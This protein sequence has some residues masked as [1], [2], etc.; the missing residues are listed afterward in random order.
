MT[1]KPIFYSFAFLCFLIIIY[2]PIFGIYAHTDS[3]EFFWNAKRN[4]IFHHV[5]IQGGRP[6]FGF[7]LTAL[8]QWTDSIADLKYIR[9]ISFFGNSILLMAFYNFLVRNNFSNKVAIALTIFFACSSFICLA[10]SWTATFQIGW[11]MLAG[12]MSA[13]FCLSATN[14]EL[15][16][17]KKILNLTAAIVTGLVSLMLY[18]P[19]FT[20]FIFIVFLAFEKRNDLRQVIQGAAIY[21][22]IFVLYF[23]LFKAILW[24]TGLPP[25][26]RSSGIN[27]DVFGKLGWFFDNALL[28]SMKFNLLLVRNSFA[29]MFRVPVMV[30]FLFSTV[31]Y[32]RKDGI[33]RN[34]LSYAVIIIS[35]YF[36]AYLPNLVSVENHASNRS[37]G[38]VVLLN[39]YFLYKMIAWLITSERMQNITFILVTLLFCGFGFTNLRY[40]VTKIHSAEYAILKAATRQILENDPE[41][42][43]DTINIIR[44]TRQFLEEQGIV[45][46]ES[47]GEIGLLS[48]SVDWA[49]LPMF[50]AFI[51]EIAAETGHDPSVITLNICDSSDEHVCLTRG[52]VIVVGEEFLLNR[53]RYY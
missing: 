25:L 52:P 4:P 19:S 14:P 53:K 45:Q 29:N 21:L 44:P 1:E 46:R 16:K 42:R 49:T 36:L 6:I 17:R 32:F 5:F 15:D 13:R 7:F 20:F 41:H 3:Y 33:T 38:T 43:I 10:M 48:N 2:F 22:L 34:S 35:V 28:H 31:L 11:A 27:I 18:Q 50:L 30:L 26:G 24:Y 39:A 40:G 51:D 9:L 37:L 8:F 12:F 47:G 23:F